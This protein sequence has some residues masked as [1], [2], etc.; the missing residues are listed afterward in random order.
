M[1]CWS[2]VLESDPLGFQISEP[3]RLASGWISRRLHCRRLYWSAARCW[4][5]TR[6]SLPT[7]TPL[8]SLSSWNRLRIDSCKSPAIYCNVYLLS[9]RPVQF[10]NEILWFSSRSVVRYYLNAFYAARKSGVAKKPYNPILGETFRCRL[11]S[12]S[13]VVE[14]TVWFHAAVTTWTEF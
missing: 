13:L 4:R 7:L 5:C 8:W 12:F 14:N 3:F 11:V 6:I 1:V 9:K 2:G 10:V